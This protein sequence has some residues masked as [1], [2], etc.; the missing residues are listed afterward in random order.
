MITVCRTTG[1][2]GWL[3]ESPID[4]FDE[5]AAEVARDRRETAHHQA[6]ALRR[7]MRDAAARPSV[8]AY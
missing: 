8:L 4:I 5:H 1:A 3:T 6:L 2:T 7:V